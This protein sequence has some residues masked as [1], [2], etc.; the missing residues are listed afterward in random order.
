[1][2]V[3]DGL[4]R[5]IAAAGIG[6]TYRNDGSPYAAAEAGVTILAVPDAPDRSVAL[7]PYPGTE[8]SDR[9]PWRMPRMQIRTRGTT[10]P[11]VVLEL[12]DACRQVLHALG[13]VTLTDSD[14]TR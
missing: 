5:H 1:M 4:A 8:D 11:R 13:P 3:Y 14:S 2:T 7:G 12:D 10:D 6:L 9:N